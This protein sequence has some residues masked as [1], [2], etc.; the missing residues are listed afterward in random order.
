MAVS[1]SYF[2]ILLIAFAKCQ[3]GSASDFGE[4]TEIASSNLSHATISNSSGNVINL[5]TE[6]NI[7]EALTNGFPYDYMDYGSAYYNPGESD[8][9]APDGTDEIFTIVEDNNDKRY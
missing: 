6:T 7:G 3:D 8:D 5:G 1:I 9:I 4:I 2:L